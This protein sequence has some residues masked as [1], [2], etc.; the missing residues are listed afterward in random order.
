M[1][2]RPSIHLRIGR[3]ARLLGVAVATT[4][5]LMTWS[6]NASAKPSEAVG[7]PAAIGIQTT[8][9]CVVVLPFSSCRT[10]SVPAHSQGHF[11]RFALSGPG[12]IA[13]QVIDSRN[14][15]IVRTGTAFGGKSQ[16]TL[17]NVYSWYELD[18]GGGLVAGC[19][20]VIWNW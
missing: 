11:V 3:A 20:G 6:S 5:V 16:T 10:G 8:A 13:Y 18:V 14:G 17:Y 1:K 12:C 19:V 15:V 2:L 7:T 4:A 9:Q